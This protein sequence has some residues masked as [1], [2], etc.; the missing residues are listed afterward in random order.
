M[1]RVKLHVARV[2]EDL[3]K[4]KLA[5]ERHRTVFELLKQRKELQN[6][7]YSPEEIDDALPLPNTKESVL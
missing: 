4:E 3:A 1:K 6:L 2:E 7:G 5:Q